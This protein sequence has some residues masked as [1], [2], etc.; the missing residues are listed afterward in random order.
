MD[1][2]NLIQSSHLHWVSYIILYLGTFL[3]AIFMVFS[4]VFLA[5]HSNLSK[6]LIAAALILGVLS[7]Q[8]F[9]YGVGRLLGKSARVLHWT[10]KLTEKF[11]RHFHEHPFRTL[12]VSKFVYG[13]H[14]PSLMRSGMLKIPLAN[15]IKAAFPGTL[16][17]LVIITGLSYALSASYILIKVY[18]KDIGLGFLSLF[19]LYLLIQYLVSKKFKKDI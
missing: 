17:W 19:L 16:I 4:G 12:L 10:N 7:E 1:L 8:L 9:W 3:D 6:F 18:I 13:T 5:V 15:F 14:R 11:D 2:I